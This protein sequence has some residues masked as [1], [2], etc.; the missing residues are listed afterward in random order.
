[1]VLFFLLTLIYMLVP[2]F[3]ETQIGGGAVESQGGRST[4]GRTLRGDTA[5][6]S[7]WNFCLLCLRIR[8]DRR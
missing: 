8:L 5:E 1:M 6:Q 4:G 3:V 2:G 7:A